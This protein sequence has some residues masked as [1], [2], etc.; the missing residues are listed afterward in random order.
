MRVLTTAFFLCAGASVASGNAFV[1][2]DFSAKATGR[3]DATI[4]TTSDGSSICYNVAGIAGTRGTT[5]YVG[6]TVIRA[7]GSFKDA[8]DGRTTETESPP[9]ITPG[10]YFTH[11]LLDNVVVGLGFHTPFGSRLVWGDDS[12]S[13]DEVREQAL[14]TYFITPAIGVDL[15]KQIPGLR[16]GVGVDLVPATVQLQQ[17]IFFGDAVGS[18]KL[19]GNAFGIGG[20]VGVTYVPKAA[21]RL[22][23]G[24]IWR[25]KIKLDFEGDGDF[26]APAPYR[27]QLPRDGA[28]KTSITLPQSIGVGMAVRPHKDIEV[29]ANAMWMA[30]SAVDKLE[31]TLPNDSV[32]VSPRDYEDRVTVRL[33]A[34]YTAT[35]K[36]S[37]RAGYMYDPTPIPSTTLTAALPDANRHDVTVGMGYKFGNYGVDLGFLWV[38]PSTKDTSDEPNMPNYKGQYGVEVHVAA[39]SFSGQFGE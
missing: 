2:N 17:D 21:P 16:L 25:S 13:L 19:G 27:P 9:A 24:A 38:I 3:G 30:W 14:R 32:T 5:F 35:E 26:D 37:L 15:D 23:F 39:L 8:R 11:R 29:E 20:R 18:A 12:P 10:I 34:E 31:I 28:I 6:G 22:S 4:A 7:V 36:L 33:G 1:L